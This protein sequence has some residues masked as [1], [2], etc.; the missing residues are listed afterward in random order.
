VPL[1]PKGQ[2]E[3]GLL[4]GMR[5]TLQPLWEVHPSL[6][7]DESLLTMEPSSP[8]HLRAA[9]VSAIHMTESVLATAGD[10]SRLHLFFFDEQ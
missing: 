2:G 5:T 10:D 8:P 3:E 1:G 7:G 6:E 4:G 9:P